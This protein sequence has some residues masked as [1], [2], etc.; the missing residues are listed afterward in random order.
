MPSV[1]PRAAVADAEEAD[2]AQAL[3]RAQH[4]GIH[5]RVVQD[6][7]VGRTQALDQLRPVAR[8]ALVE[9]H[10]PELAQGIEV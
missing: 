8:H 9:V 5:H 7:R 1:L 2:E 6:H 10:L 3:A 4:L